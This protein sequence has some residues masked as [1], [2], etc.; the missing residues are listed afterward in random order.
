MDR[1]PQWREAIQ[2]APDT[3]VVKG[4]MQDYVA[5]I[6]PVLPLLPKGCREALQGED[7][8]VQS[9]AVSLLREELRFDGPEDA[10]SLLNDIAHTFAAAAVRI[11]QL[12]P[13]PQLAPTP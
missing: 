10:R 3:Q 11:T 1:F 5:S 4:V 6:S 8:D 9:I 13:R 2:I 7:L 12:H